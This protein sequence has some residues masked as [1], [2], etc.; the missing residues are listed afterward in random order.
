[1]RRGM[2]VAVL[3]LLVVGP[4]PAR[5]QLRSLVSIDRVNRKLNGQ[6]VDYTHNHGQDNRI[7]SQILGMPRDMYVYL[8]PG[9]NPR[10]AYPLL[11]YLHFSNTDEHA[12]FVSNRV[13]ELDR[14]I[15]CGE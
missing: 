15:S 10:Q 12:F 9:Y 3:A 11:L 1:M 13:V 4:T 2:I 14:K 5:A 6:I 8:P 7:Y